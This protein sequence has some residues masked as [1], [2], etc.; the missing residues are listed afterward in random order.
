MSFKAL[1][2]HLHTAASLRPF[3]MNFCGFLAWLLLY[4][5]VGGTL[6]QTETETE[7]LKT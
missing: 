5:P 7:T 4:L 3:I 2:A 1:A 6:S